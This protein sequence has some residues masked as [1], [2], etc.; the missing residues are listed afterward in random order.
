MNLLPTSLTNQIEYELLNFLM[1]NPNLL[2][3]SGIKLEELF[4]ERSKVLFAEM[5]SM[6][7]LELEINPVTVC[8]RLKKPSDYFDYISPEN[9]SYSIKTNA[10]FFE[11]ARMIKEDYTRRQLISKLSDSK[12]TTEFLDYAK[13]I[14]E[15]HQKIQIN[16]LE[17]DFKDFAV[18]SAKRR[19][20]DDTAPMTSWN[21]FNQL[22]K[23]ERGN[24]VIIGARP[25]IGKTAFCLSLALDA[26]RLNSRVLFVSLEMNK[27]QLF[28][29]L[30][31]NV[32]KIN[33]KVYQQGVADLNLAQE[34]LTPL[35][36]DNKLQLLFK[37]KLLSSDLRQFRGYD[38]IIIDYLQ[39]LSDQ[40]R[41][42]ENIRIQ[43]IS[44]NLKILAGEN[45]CVVVAAAQ[46]NRD[47]EK[48]KRKPNLSDLRS[49]GSLE[50]DADIACLLHRE[51]RKTTTLEILVAKNRNGEVGDI[52][53]DYSPH[54]NLFQPLF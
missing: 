45:D 36:K 9:T 12:D 38:L 51:D 1:F 52:M 2:V 30:L 28:Y 32:T 23:F 21:N 39:L 11:R 15:L 16:T 27:Q 33:S 37:P 3:E 35:F 40:S 49:S 5:Q 10:D 25:S 42:N 41:E 50:Q 4:N 46:L 14:D 18:Q 47:N 13:G 43:N 17:E 7:L 6:Q 22:I 19:D 29:R 44:R 54:L 53:M 48:A 8:Q 24:F 34:K 31:S 20:N 26:S